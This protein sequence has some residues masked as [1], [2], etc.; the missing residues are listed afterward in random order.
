MANVS[1]EVV[2]MMFFLTLSSVNVDFLGHELWKRTYTT[3]KTLPNTQCVKHVGKTEFV[4]A[5]LHLEYE[6]YVVYV[7]SVS[8]VALPS[9]SPFDAVYSSRRPQIFDLIAEEAPIKVLAEYLDFANIFSLDLTS[10]LS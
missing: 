1:L 9:F 8:S 4:A 2:L 3:K 7:G 10:K 5:R 6:T